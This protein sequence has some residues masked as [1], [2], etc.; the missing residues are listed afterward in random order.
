MTIHTILEPMSAVRFFL[1]SSFSVILFSS[2]IFSVIFFIKA[3]HWRRAH[4]PV[5]WLWG[6]ALAGW[7]VS[8]TNILWNTVSLAPFFEGFHFV[9]NINLVP[10]V[11]IVKMV[12]TI[13]TTDPSFFSIINLFGNIGFFI[14]IG[15]FLPF[16][17]K[18]FA[19]WWK[20]VLF[21]FF[22]S[23][24]IESWQLFLPARG[25]DIDDIILNTLGTLIG[26]FVFFLFSKLFPKILKSIRR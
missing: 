20:T 7:I 19:A 23:L 8:L 1:Q 10:I 11:S 9:G 12:K 14:P 22:L 3:I 26:Y 17:S 5:N 6:I 25:T 15:F 2:L 16:V 18:K 24:L 4:L 21:G 13:F